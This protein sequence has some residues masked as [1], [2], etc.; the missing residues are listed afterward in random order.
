MNRVVSPRRFNAVER[1]VCFDRVIQYAEQ[2]QVSYY[3]ACKQTG[4]E[5]YNF[6]YWKKQMMRPKEI[7]SSQ[8]K[9]TVEVILVG[10]S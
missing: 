6:T 8:Y 9:P 5:Y 1:K 10:A 7:V 4:V 2:N 3:V